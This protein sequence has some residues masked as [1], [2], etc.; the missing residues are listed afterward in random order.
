MFSFNVFSKVTTK[1]ENTFSFS[2]NSRQVKI[3]ESVEL[4]EI[5]STGDILLVHELKNQNIYRN[6]NTNLDVSLSQLSF[7]SDQRQKTFS[8]KPNGVCT[9][10]TREGLFR[11]ITIPSHDSIDESISRTVTLNRLQTGI[12]DMIVKLDDNQKILQNMADR[13]N[14][15]NQ[16]VYSLNIAMHLLHDWREQGKKLICNMECKTKKENLETLLECSV[17]NGSQFVLTNQ[18]TIIIVLEQ[19]NSSSKCFSYP[20]LYLEPGTLWNRA[21]PLLSSVNNL[22]RPFKVTLLLNFSYVESQFSMEIKR[23]EFNI[24]DL[25]QPLNTQY[26]IMKKN[27]DL[28]CLKS[29]KHRLN[30]L[31]NMEWNG[32][33]S[34]LTSLISSTSHGFKLRFN[35]LEE[36]FVKNWQSILQIPIRHDLPKEILDRELVSLSQNNFSSPTSLISPYGHELKLKISPSIQTM[37]SFDILLQGSNFHSLILARHAILAKF[38]HFLSF[39]S[40]L[41]QNEAYPRLSSKDELVE[42]IKTMQNF[43]DQIQNIHV[44]LEQ[45]ERSVQLLFN[46]VNNMENSEP[47]SLVL[48]KIISFDRSVIELFREI[49]QSKCG[50]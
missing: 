47:L 34:H 27:L 8:L 2:K 22:N 49:R 9:V 48:S 23:Q 31:V 39:R 13:E 43:G 12:R 5:M 3:P 14:E 33:F 26:V 42:L 21:I 46:N 10:L 35:S 41:L 24:M 29:T 6:P 45:L 37:H 25:V 18:W 28:V 1:G 11:H 38:Q 16:E 30:A 15:L 36:N 7:T 20:I 40:E 4:R 19:E 44:S 50:F 32:N 17:L